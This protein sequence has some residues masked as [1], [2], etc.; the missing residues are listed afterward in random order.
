MGVVSCDLLNMRKVSERKKG[1]RP[2][3]K[4]LREIDENHSQKIAPDLSLV[5]LSPSFSFRSSTPMKPFIRRGRKAVRVGKVAAGVR[6][7]A[8][9]GASRRLSNRERGRDPC[10][11]SAWVFANPEGQRKLS[12]SPLPIPSALQRQHFRAVGV[13]S[14]CVRET[15]SS[16]VNSWPGLFKA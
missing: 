15:L 13:W 1:S 6:G 11:N 2:G 16:L 12:R 5:S 4:V 8:P 10:K 3:W 14:V 7:F 9:L